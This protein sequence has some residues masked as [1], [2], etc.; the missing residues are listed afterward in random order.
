MKQVCASVSSDSVNMTQLVQWNDL[1]GEG[2]SRIKKS[3]SYFMWKFTPFLTCFTP[4][5]CLHLLNQHCFANSEGF[6]GLLLS[7]FVCKMKY[8]FFKVFFLHYKVGDDGFWKGRGAFQ[9]CGRLCCFCFVPHPKRTSDEFCF[10]FFL[11]VTNVLPE[12]I[13]EMILCIY[14]P[15]FRSLLLS[16]YHFSGLFGKSW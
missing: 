9:N 7:Y 2:G 13:S 16:V 5:C 10:L 11:E 8:R 15:S 4:N 1:Y 14:C 3:L 12:E 6:Q